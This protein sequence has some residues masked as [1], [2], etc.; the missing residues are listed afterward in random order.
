MMPLDFKGKTRYNKQRIRAARQDG[1]L[2]KK[3][4]TAYLPPWL[5]GYN[6]PLLRLRY[7]GHLKKN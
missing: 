4:D 6:K 3:S 1:P 7:N 2:H 5:N